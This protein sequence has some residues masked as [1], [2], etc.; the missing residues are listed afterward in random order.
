[1][2]SAPKKTFLVFSVCESIGT[3]KSRVAKIKRAQGGKDR[4]KKEREKEGR[5]APEG[6]GGGERDR[7][8]DRWSCMLMQQAAHET[9][10]SVCARCCVGCLLLI[11]C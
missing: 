5:K 1:M 8:R 3:E 9:T 4:G 7:E 11:R 6:G 2:Y 10:A